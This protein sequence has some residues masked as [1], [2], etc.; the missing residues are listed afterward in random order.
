MGSDVGVQR[1]AKYVGSSGAVIDGE[2]G[3]RIFADKYIS[4]LLFAG[5]VTPLGMLDWYE[6]P[7]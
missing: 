3:G 5:A 4:V 7:F 2:G 1:R 6:Y